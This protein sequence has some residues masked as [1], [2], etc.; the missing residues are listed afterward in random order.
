M[1]FSPALKVLSKTARVSRLRILMRTSVWPAAR[2]RLRDLDVEAVVGRVLEL[3]E[4]LALDLDR[5]NQAGHNQLFLSGI[6]RRTKGGL[7]RDRAGRGVDGLACDRRLARS[8]RQVVNATNALTVAR[9]RRRADPVSANASRSTSAYCVEG[10]HEAKRED[11]LSQR[12]SLNVADDRRE[13]TRVALVVAI[14]LPQAPAHAR[15]RIG[16][17][18][19]RLRIWER[20]HLEV[21]PRACHRQRPLVGK[22]TIEGVT[23][24]PRPL[25]N[26]AHR[27][28]GR[29]DR[30]VER[31]RGLDNALPGLILALGPF[32]QLVSSRHLKIIAQL[33]AV[34]CVYFTAQRSAPK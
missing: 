8:S 17:A 19:P 1:N 11:L 3:E 23:L 33:C 13:I 30:R 32:L 22:M 4:H 28:P 18:A 21:Q 14:E 12:V 29:P 31:N 6:P 34:K 26:R 20:V 10:W 27:G 16:D 25:R 24:D 15:I 9:S 7:C 2:G 5:F